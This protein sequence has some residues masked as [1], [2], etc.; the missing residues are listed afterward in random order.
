MRTS[1]RRRLFRKQRRVNPSVHDPRP[2]LAQRSAEL[3]ATECVA[4]VNANADDI[5][6][7]DG[8][9]GERFERL[10]DDERIAPLTTRRGSQY[11]QPARCDDSDAERLRAGIDEVN[12]RPMGSGGQRSSWTMPVSCRQIRVAVSY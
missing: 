3:I 4:R 9:D 6:R 2:P 10:I 5:A 8:V 12:L 7:L 11:V 1:L